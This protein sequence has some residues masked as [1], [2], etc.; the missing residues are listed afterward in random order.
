MNAKKCQRFLIFSIACLSA[1]KIIFDIS[2][3]LGLF[4]HTSKIL[5]MLRFLMASRA[6]SLL[7]NVT[8]AHPA[9]ESMNYGVPPHNGWKFRKTAVKMKVLDKLTM[10]SK[11]FAQLG[12]SRFSHDEHIFNLSIPDEKVVRDEWLE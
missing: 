6:E 8:K 10:M 9:W 7:M 12:F 2:I 3:N 4:S 1:V 5:A 11:T